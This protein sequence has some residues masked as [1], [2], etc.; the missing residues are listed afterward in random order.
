M[1]QDLNNFFSTWFSVTK[2]RLSRVRISE[3]VTFW[4]ELKRLLVTRDVDL[5]AKPHN[6]KRLSNVVEQFGDWLFWNESQLR[7]VV[8]LLNFV[9]LFEDFVNL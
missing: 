8:L 9:S 2:K 3:V 5:F 1:E 4:E 6:S 7:N